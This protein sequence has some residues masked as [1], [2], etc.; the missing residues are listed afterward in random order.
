IVFPARLL[1]AL[2]GTLS[3]LLAGGVAWRL[4]GSPVALVFAP[5]VLAVST[6]SQFHAWAYLNVD[7]IGTFFVLAAVFHALGPRGRGVLGDGL[8]AGAFAGLAIGSKYS[9]YPILL[10]GLLRIAF[11]GE[12]ARLSRAAAFLATAVV[13][14]AV[15]TPG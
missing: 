13:V 15:T 1:F 6:V 5:V 7:T 10:P 12:R 9:L 8:A 3:L 2:L 11:G 14:F 4:T